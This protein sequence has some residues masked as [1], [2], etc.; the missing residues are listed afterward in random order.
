MDTKKEV[1][2]AS[3]VARGTHAVADWVEAVIQQFQLPHTFAA[4]PASDLTTTGV[5]EGLGDALPR[6]AGAPMAGK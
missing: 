5:L 6:V 4:N 2:S 3:R 1:S